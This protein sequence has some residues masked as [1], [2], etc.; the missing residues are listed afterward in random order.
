MKIL[1]ILIPFS[2]GLA[3]VIIGYY[4][5]LETAQRN[6]FNNTK[7]RYCIKTITNRYGIL[8]EENKDAW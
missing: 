3:A 2:I 4:I 6:C 7:C 5:G 8:I 1:D